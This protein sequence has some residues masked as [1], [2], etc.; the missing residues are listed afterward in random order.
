MPYISDD[1]DDDDRTDPGDPKDICRECGARLS[2]EN[3]LRDSP[4]HAKTCSRYVTA[5]GRYL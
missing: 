4:E 3:E 2:A 5:D 1:A